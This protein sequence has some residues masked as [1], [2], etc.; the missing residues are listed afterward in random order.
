MEF[1]F[2]GF[3]ALGPSELCCSVSGFC[4]VLADG[5]LWLEIYEDVPFETVEPSAVPTADFLDFDFFGI[6]SGFRG[7]MI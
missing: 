7:S 3:A 2:F 5:L 6:A 4:S 1:S